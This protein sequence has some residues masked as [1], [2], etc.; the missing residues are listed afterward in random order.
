MQ[1]N[2]KVAGYFKTHPLVKEF[3]FTSDFCAFFNEHNANNQSANLAKQGK[4][5][6]VT[7]VTRDE[8][9][10]WE[11][12]EAKTTTAAPDAGTV[13]T[14]NPPPP[15]APELTPEEKV[16]AAQTALDQA[17]KNLA[18]AMEARAAMDSDPAATTVSKGAG[19]KAVNNAKKA[20]AD[21]DAMLANAKVDAGM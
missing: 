13:G 18:D 17:N 12:E 10:A 7:K 4:P 1:I 3:W 2:N 8:V 15:P 14:Q 5:S 21:A 6:G 20:V 11:A 19:T 9:T 16:A